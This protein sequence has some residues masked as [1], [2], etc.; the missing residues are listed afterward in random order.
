MFLAAEKALAEKATGPLPGGYS[1]GDKV[2]YTGTSVTLRDG[3]RVEHNQAGVVTGALLDRLSVKFPKAHINCHLT[4]LSRTPLLLDGLLD[5]CAVGEKVYFTGLSYAFADGDKVSYGLGGEVTGAATGPNTKGSSV[6]VTFPG[7]KTRTNCRLVELSRT[8]PPQLPDGYAVGE[9]VWFI[10]LSETLSSG[11]ELEHAQAG[12]VTGPA[13][14]PGNE[15][16]GLYVMLTGNKG[17]T[18]CRLAELSRAA[19]SAADK[20]AAEAEAARRAA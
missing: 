6:A 12:E 20:A 3:K 8:A 9:K 13:T 2:F 4:D 1:V 14:G 7:N 19:P 10:G 18:G 17:H 11:E 5:G 15:V 16:H